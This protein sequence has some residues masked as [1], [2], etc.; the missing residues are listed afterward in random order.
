M[1][2]LTPSVH[3]RLV[4]EIFTSIH[5]RYD[6]MNHLLSLGCDFFWRHHVTRHLTLSPGDLVLD[7][8]CGTGDLAL[9]IARSHPLNSIYGV[10]FSLPMLDVAKK[11]MGREKTS[12]PII[13]IRADALQLPFPENT[14]HA[15]TVAFGIR[16][17]S[18][19]DGAL[20][21]LIRVLKP[22]GKMIVL[23]MHN[24]PRVF[25]R[26][27]FLLYC[28]TVLKGVAKFASKNPPA[29]DYLVNSIKYFPSPADF[30]ALMHNA[31]LDHVLTT[32]LFP[33]I[34]YLH[35]GWK[36]SG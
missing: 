26:F 12:C 17:M 1:S 27:L 35:E 30:G 32:P 24:P 3:R 22:G 7:V 29:Y 4:E 18:P 5:D 13:L 9:S 14:F 20:K 31:G 33:G 8:A 34:T 23:E 36:R 16:N 15:V 28:R 25:L 2:F 11:K 21:E 6:V 10:D 19:V